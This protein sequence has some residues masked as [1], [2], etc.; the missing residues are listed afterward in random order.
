MFLSNLV[1]KSTALD[2]YFI[3]Q[4]FH[5]TALLDANYGTAYLR[6]RQVLIIE[7]VIREGQRFIPQLEQVDVTAWAGLNPRTYKKKTFATNCRAVL[8]LLR[9]RTSVERQAQSADVRAKETQFETFLSGCFSVDILPKDWNAEGALVPSLTIGSAVVERVKDT[10]KP[11]Q[12]QD[13]TAF[14]ASTS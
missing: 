4:A 8:L 7:S 10:I 13:L 6:I 9:S 12:S 11:Y 1:R 5:L 14:K 2:K 3:Q